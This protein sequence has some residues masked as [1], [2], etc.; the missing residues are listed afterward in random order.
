MSTSITVTVN[1]IITIRP[2]AAWRLAPFFHVSGG[3]LSSLGLA[4]A[5]LAPAR[6]CTSSLRLISAYGYTHSLRAQRQGH[7]QDQECR[8]AGFAFGR[9]YGSR[10]PQR[11]CLS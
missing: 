11:R 7:A 3:P 8:H 4:R 2:L 10:D 1:L 6:N 9:P 5:R